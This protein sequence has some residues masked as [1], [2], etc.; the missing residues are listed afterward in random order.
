[1]EEYLRILKKVR[2]EG[3]LKPNRT[4]IDAY[5]IFGEKFEHDMS[6][7]F[8]FLTTKFVPIKMIMGENE[9]FIKGLNDKR[10]LQ[11]RGIHIWDEWCSSIGLKNFNNSE[12]LN[13]RVN[14]AYGLAKSQLDECLILDRGLTPRL[15]EFEKSGAKVLDN[16]IIFPNGLNE[17][18]I[19]ASRK[20]E[21]LI[22]RDLGPI[23][24]YQWR[25]FNGKYKSMDS[26]KN[27]G[28]DQLE[29]VVE[30]LKKNPMDRRMIVSAWNPNQLSQMALPPCHYEF[31]V[32]VLGDKLNLEWSQRS[33]DTPMGLP[34]NIAGYATILHLLCEQSGYEPGK[35]IGNL[36]DVHIYEN[37][38]N[39]VE[40]QL[41]RKPK[42]LCSVE[43]KDFKNIFDWK[44]TQT[45][46]NNYEYDKNKIDFGNIYKY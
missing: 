3:I 28:Y 1:M 41:S 25:N 34:F 2:D 9:F 17:N 29:N 45:K 5:A 10:W 7:G 13:S 22:Q 35:L 40:E 44:H 42:Q 18:V 39:G 24:G 30:T 31:Q 14:W 12:N 4:G 16:E 21:Q 33:V 38:M 32:G 36:K 11:K 8:P 15:E 43:T 46:R 6:E 19:N 23:Y 37:Q 20:L 27:N 26:F